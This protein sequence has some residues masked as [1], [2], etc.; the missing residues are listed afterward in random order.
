MGSSKGGGTSTTQNTYPP[1][2]MSALQP[3]ISGATR[4]M[5][6]FMNQ[7]FNVL[8]GRDPNAGQSKRGGGFPRGGGGGRFDPDVLAQ[9]AQGISA[10]PRRR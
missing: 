4:N 8:Q 9:L 2:L 5:G 10:A 6:T 7:G 3:L 1:W